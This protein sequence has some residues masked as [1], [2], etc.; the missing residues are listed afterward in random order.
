M[1]APVTLRFG[2]SSVVLKPRQYARA[3]RLV[4]ED[5]ALV[6]EL[7]PKALARQ[8]SGLVA[9]DGAA[10]VDAAHA[11]HRLG[12]V[13]VCYPGAIIPRSAMP[14]NILPGSTRKASP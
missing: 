6:P 12:G 5:G 1:S 4:A 3:L 2:E 11:G 14:A 8:L 7:R 10:P 13:V 9:E